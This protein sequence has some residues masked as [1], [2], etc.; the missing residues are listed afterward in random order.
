M[1]DLE[2]RVAEL[3]R[4]VQQLTELSSLQAAQIDRLKFD[5]EMMGYPVQH[6]DLFLVEQTARAARQLAVAA[7]G[8]S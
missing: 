1:D 6:S 2:D 4:M 3:E 5:V 7:L 8:T